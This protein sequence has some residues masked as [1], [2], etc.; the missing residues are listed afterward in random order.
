MITLTECP[1]C[2]IKV[3]PSA[4]GICPS[5]RKSVINMNVIPF[6]EDEETIEINEEHYLRTHMNQF[7]KLSRILN[8]ARVLILGLLLL[9]LFWLTTILPSNYYLYLNICQAIVLTLLFIIERKWI[10]SN[11][12]FIWSMLPILI[13]IILIF[14][15]IIDFSGYLAV[16][17][18]LLILVTILSYVN[19]EISWRLFRKRE[20]RKKR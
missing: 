9:E 8:Y 14:T 1:S 6:P 2:H 15:R 17:I 5:C 11:F 12:N 10:K 18:S 3:L 19:Y 7:E 4:D 20:F 16:F 13:S